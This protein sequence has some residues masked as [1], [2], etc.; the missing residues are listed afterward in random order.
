MPLLF[1]LT[2]GGLTLDLLDL[3]GEAAFFD[4]L[5]LDFLPAAAFLPLPPAFGF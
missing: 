5:A 4:L 2:L 1:L 3:E